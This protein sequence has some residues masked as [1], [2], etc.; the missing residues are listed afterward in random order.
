[1]QT[2]STAASQGSTS[3]Q[4]RMR[5]WLR[6]LL[7]HRDLERE[8]AAALAA[9]MLSPEVTDAQLAAVLAALASKGECAAELTGLAEA[10]VERMVEMP[11][12]QAA[13]DTAGTGASPVKTFNVSTAA[14]FVIAAAGLRIAKHG[15]RAASSRSG[16]ADVLAALGVNIDCPPA[17]SQRALDEHG[18]CFLFAPL[19]HPAL[20]RLA[21]VRRQLGIRTAF[22]LVGPIV[23]PCLAQYRILGVSEAARMRPVA[24]T[25]AALGVERAWVVRGEDGLDEVTLSGK[26]AV[27]EISGEQLR[28]L[29][30]APE[31]FGLR[32]RDCSQLQGDGAAA[33]AQT[34]T[35]VLAGE[36]RD[37]ARDLVLLN[38]AAAIHVRTGAGYAECAE[39]AAEALDSGRALEKL[40]ALRQATQT[41]EGA[42]R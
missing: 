16:S 23:N 30:L 32:R 40:H 21:P 4:E 22:N 20:A 14:A 13:L 39:R 37:G 33:N 5:G 7:A 28:D 3:A 29:E 1:M 12:P 9:A 26:T 19:Y 34:I 10:L 25:L 2:Y 18:I 15:G 17:T 8:E 42:E 27:I 11:R 36:R 6:A 41:P 24:E 35:A 31:E 38:G